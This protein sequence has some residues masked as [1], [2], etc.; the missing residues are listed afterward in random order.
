MCILNVARKI[1]FIQ[2]CCF[3]EQYQYQ[4][5]KKVFILNPPSNITDVANTGVFFPKDYI[6]AAQ[7]SFQI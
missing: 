5:L 4:F 3:T 2:Y 1:I 7:N 6:W